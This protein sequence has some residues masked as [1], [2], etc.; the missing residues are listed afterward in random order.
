M[1]RAINIWG[2]IVKNYNFVPFMTNKYEYKLYT[3]LKEYIYLK[4]VLNT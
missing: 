4:R 3:L 1:R 2:A